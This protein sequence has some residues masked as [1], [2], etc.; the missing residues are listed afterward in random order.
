M[1]IHSLRPISQP[2]L[3]SSVDSDGFLP[4]KALE[5]NDEAGYRV[6]VPEEA[7]ELE[8]QLGQVSKEKNEAVR[9]QDFEKVR[10]EIAAVLATGKE[11]NKAETE[12]GQEGGSR[13]SH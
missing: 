2:K 11:V 9:G 5:L 3:F 1:K 12:A 13:E 4:D 8:R 6:M 10:A 7:R